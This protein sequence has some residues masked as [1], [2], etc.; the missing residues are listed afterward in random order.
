MLS[1]GLVETCACGGRGAPPVTRCPSGRA[2][3]TRADPPPPTRRGQGL[4]VDYSSGG[5]APELP[6][7]AAVQIAGGA[8]RPEPAARVQQRRFVRRPRAWS[9][10][11]PSVRPPGPPP[12]LA[13]RRPAFRP[14]VGR[15]RQPRRTGPR[16][17]PASRAAR[18]HSRAAWSSPRRLPLAGLGAR[19]QVAGTGTLDRGAHL[20]G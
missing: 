10:G 8:N 16:P 3:P 4:R 6:G 9:S 13:P 19:S 15:S 12:P 2:F 7:G 20:Q 18:P 5:G 1:L 17:P 11:N 14:P